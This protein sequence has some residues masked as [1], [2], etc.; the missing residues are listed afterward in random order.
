VL[1]DQVMRASKAPFV[2]PESAKT[3]MKIIL[4]AEK[5]WREHRVMNWSD[6]PA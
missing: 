5:S 4:L 3:T 6:L 1:F 2:S